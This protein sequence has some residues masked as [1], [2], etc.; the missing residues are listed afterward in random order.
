MYVGKTNKVGNMF[1]FWQ[2]EVEYSWQ[3]KHN[4][5]KQ[6]NKSELFIQTFESTY[7]CVT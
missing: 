3:R 4:F 7:T 5:Y 1:P 2:I 6:N